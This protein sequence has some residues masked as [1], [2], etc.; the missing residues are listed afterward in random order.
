MVSTFTTARN[1]EKPAAGDQIGTWG[2]ASINP[3]LDIVDA[4]MGQ[5]TTISGA[6]GSVVLAA[7]QF[8][9]AQ[10]TF[11]STLL[12]NMTATFPSTFTGPYTIYNACTGSSAFTITLATTVAGAQQVGCPPGEPFEIFNDG[13]NIRYRNFGRI[14]SYMDIAASSTPNWNDV[15][16]PQKPYLNCDGTVFSSA[17]Y[18][19]LAAQIGTTL[20]DYKGRSRSYLNQG[21]GRLTSSA[22]VDG[23][24]LFAAGGSQAILSSAHIPPVLITDLGHVHL[25]SVLVYTNE[26]VDAGQTAAGGGSPAGAFPTYTSCSA[27]TGITAGSSNS[28]TYTN[29][30]PTTI[31]GLTLIRAA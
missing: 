27:T 18:P 6:A 28:T 21:T 19:V 30:Q 10:I 29:I 31:G 5:V 25:V 8:R 15:C 7:A 23:N 17:T 20:P 16:T 26:T 9:C 3:D 11:N 1:M 4:G 14:G 2:T 24:T 13:S 12:A 22:G